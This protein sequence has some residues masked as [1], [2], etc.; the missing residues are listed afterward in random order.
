MLVLFFAFIVPAVL[1]NVSSA[2]KKGPGKKKEAG[3]QMFFN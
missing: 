3:V 2:V 1:H